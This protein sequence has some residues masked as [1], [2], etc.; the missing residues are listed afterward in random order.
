[1]IHTVKAICLGIAAAAYCH[2][3]LPPPGANTLSNNTDK[4]KIE[5]W[6]SFS[7]R[8]RFPILICAVYTVG[9]MVYLLEM[10]RGGSIGSFS[11]DQNLNVIKTWQLV[12]LGVAL[13]ADALRKWSILTLNRFFTVSAI[14]CYWSSR[15]CLLEGY[16]FF[17]EQSLFNPDSSFFLYRLWFLVSTDDPHS[18]QVSHYRTLSLPPPPLLH[19][20]PRQPSCILP[21]IVPRGPLGHICSIHVSCDR[22]ADSLWHPSD[23]QHGGLV[24]VCS[25]FDLA[26]RRLGCAWRDLGYTRLG[27]VLWPIHVSADSGRGSNAGGALWTGVEGICG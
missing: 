11:V 6:H 26:R 5:H 22:A 8:I 9:T 10:V 4:I 27:A 23:Q 16:F 3:N 15:H 20:P 14:P 7:I 25:G 21:H 18:A 24:S 13:V 12:A 2:D 1:M 17:L 19:C